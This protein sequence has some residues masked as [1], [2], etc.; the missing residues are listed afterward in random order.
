MWFWLVLVSLVLGDED[1]R[2]KDV[3][4]SKKILGGGNISILF[5]PV[6]IAE[7]DTLKLQCRYW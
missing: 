4:R 1:E 7:G 5:F 3:C 2:V 6:E